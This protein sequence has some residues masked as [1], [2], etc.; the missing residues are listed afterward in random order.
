MSDLKRYQRLAPR[1]DNAGDIIS[2]EHIN[3]IQEVLARVQRE[4]FSQQDADFLGQLVEA[5]AQHPRHNAMW[6]ELVG[7]KGALSTARGQN[8]VFS[9]DERAAVLVDN[10]AVTSGWFLSRL[11]DAPSQC[12][13]REIS[14]YVLEQRE[15]GDTVAYALS[16][17]GTDF[18]PV[19]PNTGEIFRFPQDGTKLQLKATLTRQPG[20]PGPA[21]S[22]WAV[23][24]YDH[25]RA[26][27]LDAVLP[28][29]LPPD[30]ETDLPVTEIPPP[31][32]PPIFHSQLLGIGPDDH[33]PKIHR[34]SG[35]E[36]EN[37]RIDLTSEITGTM[38]WAHLPPE[39]WLLTG[40]LQL[41]RDEQGRLQQV[42]AP[43]WTATLEFT[44]ERL[45]TVRTQWAD[46]AETITLEWDAASGLLTA[47]NV[48]RE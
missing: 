3:S 15:A 22:A 25:T 41:V 42:I 44:Q 35:E 24:Y 1:V 40:R 18:Y 6:V 30:E 4:L 28:V 17:N 7:Q 14:L 33:H 5:L 26:V 36:G 12:S 38:P 34:H 46:F 29:E 21:V 20:T 47:V 39:L 2:A 11:Y 16:N 32:L 8:V 19:T 43:L 48:G 9:P 27:D 10:A 31:T 23:L 37:A 45:A 13:I